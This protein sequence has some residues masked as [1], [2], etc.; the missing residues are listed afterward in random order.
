MAQLLEDKLLKAGVRAYRN[1][2]S[3]TV[4]FE[5]P[6]ERIVKKYALACNE[7]ADF[8]KLAHIV[9]MQYFT[10]EMIYSIVEDIVS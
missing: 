5:R 8:G 4:F 10:P 7:Y 2:Y 9:A 6:A 1:P 3:N